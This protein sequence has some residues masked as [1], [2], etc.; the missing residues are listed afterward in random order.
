MSVRVRLGPDDELLAHSRALG[1]PTRNA[2]YRYVRD[3]EAMVGVAELTEHFGLN[4]NAIRQHLAKLV[5]AGLLVEERQAP[6]GRGR[7]RLAYRPDPGVAERWGGRG[8]YEVLSM[9]LLELLNSN[10]TPREVGRR[11][12]YRLAVEHGDGR[13]TLDVLVAVAR[14]LGFEPQVEPGEA[15]T[16][17]VLERCPFA[18]AAG[19]SPEIVCE[20]H[21]GI[22]EGVAEQT[23]EVADVAGLVVRSPERAG[24]RIELTVPT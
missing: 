14:R 9:L 18:E 5:D 21:R 7:P 16:D 15:G 12:G 11:A 22:A 24:C 19:V 13:G 6:A 8:P 4:H 10:R 23:G 2:V 17:V 1:D 3:A 20:L